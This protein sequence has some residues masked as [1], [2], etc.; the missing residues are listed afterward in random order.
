MDFERQEK[1]EVTNA[2]HGPTS[3]KVTTISG[4]LWLLFIF[5]RRE[6]RWKPDEN[7]LWCVKIVYLLSL[8][9]FYYYKYIIIIIIIAINNIITTIIN[10]IFII[11]I[12]V[13]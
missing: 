9:F 8:I 4:G 10:I 2:L 7:A 3:I 5:F 13:R 11:I 12:T 1:Q 6:K